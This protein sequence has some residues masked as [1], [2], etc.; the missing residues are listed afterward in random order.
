MD[1]QAKIKQSPKLPPLERRQQLLAA[2]RELFVKKGYRGTTTEEIARRAGVTKGALYFHFKTKEDL[3][4][5]LVRSFVEQ[6]EQVFNEHLKG[7]FTPKE[8]LERL[9]RVQCCHGNQKQS[10]IV[11]LWTQAWRIPRI[12]RFITSRYKTALQRFT[13][14]L[15]LSGC[16]RTVKPSEVAI[17]ICALVDGLSVMG[18]MMPSVINVDQQLKLVDTLFGSSTKIAKGYK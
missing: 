13:R 5:E 15:D 7:R 3:F 2:A 8:L 18:M 4:L 10:E 11:D 6:H 1:T 14:Q 9:W 12:K 16:A 17:M